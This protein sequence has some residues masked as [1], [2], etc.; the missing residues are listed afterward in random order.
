MPVPFQLMA[1]FMLQ[2]DE[3]AKDRSDDS[4]WSSGTAYA[5]FLGPGRYPGGRNGQWDARLLSVEA[6]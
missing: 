2:V 1:L 4:W 3:A 5:A 6:W